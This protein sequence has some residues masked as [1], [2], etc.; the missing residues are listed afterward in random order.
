MIDKNIVVDTNILLYNPEVLTLENVI[1]PFVALQELDKLKN[2]DEV[3]FEA[4]RAIRLINESSIKI[5]INFSSPELDYN[6]DLF[7]KCAKEHEA[8]LYTK[9]LALSIKA[10]ASKI[11]SGDPYKTSDGIYTGIKEVTLTDKEIAY[12][13]ENTFDNVFDLY[14]NQYLLVKNDSG[15]V[16]DKLK[17]ISNKLVNLKL[18]P[19]KIIKPL[20]DKQAFALDL[21]NDK[22]IPIKVLAG[23]YGS[24][25]TF[26][27]IRMALYHLLQKGNYSKILFVRNPIGSGEEIGHLPGSKEEKIGPFYKVIEQQLDGGELQLQQLLQYRQLEYEIPYHIKGQSISNTF[28]LV[29]EAEDMN[30]K[31]LKLIGTRIAE[32]SCICFSGDWKQ[33]EGKYM[34]DN[35]LTFL[36]NATKN[37]PLVGAVVMDDDVRST[38]SKVFA[39]LD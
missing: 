25:K 12:M 19:S 6:D 26:I 8:V 20:N 27:N 9:D 35:G 3:G 16:V 39:D 1:I 38:A 4:R 31:I 15:E 11:E 23:T 13:Y 29:D 22:D 18:P 5:D 17:W 36:L 21:L 30:K 33:A 10:N 14:P 2:S 24:G 32:G 34:K 37:N 7:I 28:I